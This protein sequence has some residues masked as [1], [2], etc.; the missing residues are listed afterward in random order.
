MVIGVDLLGQRIGQPGQRVRWLKHLAGVKR[1]EIGIVIPQ[2]FGD[3]QQDCSGSAIGLGDFGRREVGK[4]LLEV[5]RGLC[6]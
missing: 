5:R 3:F 4:P 6:Q 1:M 2:A